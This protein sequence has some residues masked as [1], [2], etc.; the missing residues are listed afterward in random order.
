MHVNILPKI[1]LMFNL[2]VFQQHVICLVHLYTNVSLLNNKLK[3]KYLSYKQ[4]QKIILTNI[5]NTIIKT[6]NKNIQLNLILYT[7]LKNFTH[8]IKQFS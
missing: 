8:N 3:L 5:V 2:E 7:I 1:Y 4:Q 6:F